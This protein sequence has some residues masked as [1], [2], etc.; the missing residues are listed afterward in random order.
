MRTLAGWL[1]HIGKTQ[2]ETVR[3]IK[4]QAAGVVLHLIGCL[5]LP[6]KMRA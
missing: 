2:E 1:D 4:A 5:A 6:V 3:R